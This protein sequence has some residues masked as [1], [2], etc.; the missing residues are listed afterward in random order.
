MKGPIYD[1]SVL[2]GLSLLVALLVYLFREQANAMVDL[3]GSYSGTPMAVAVAVLVFLIGSIFFVPQWA[4]IAA[5]IAAFGLVE[6]SAIA[7]FA[8]MVSVTAHV[9]A[10]RALS[11]R[12]EERLHIQR[13]DYLRT[14]FKRNSVQSGFLVRLIPTGPAILVNV[15]AGLFG[16]SRGGFLLGT[17]FGIMP[18]IL[19]TGIVAS[20]LISS[21]QGKQFS[22]W[23]AFGAIG[24]IALSLLTR[25]ARP[26]RPE[27]VP[28]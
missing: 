27:T 7:W 12:F 3:M 9:F 28:K 1:I 17:A 22:L 2:I 26:P 20:E 18:K 23:L 16:V 25:R 13:L 8:T 4:L 19:L 5:A 6:G 14:I 10:A 21:A 11:R 15:A 24:L